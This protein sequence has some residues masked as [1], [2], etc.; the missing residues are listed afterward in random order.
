LLNEVLGTPNNAAKPI[1]NLDNKATAKTSLQLAREAIEQGKFADA[2]EELKETEGDK[3]A[4]ALRG[5]AR[6][7][8]YFQKQSTAKAPLNKDDEDVKAAQ[9]DLSRGDNQL[10]LDQITAALQGETLKNEI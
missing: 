5:E 10:K 3:A 7:L 8:A 4:L 9:V 2:I 6:W 1:A